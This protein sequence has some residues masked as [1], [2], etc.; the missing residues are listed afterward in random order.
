M[1]NVLIVK[2]EMKDEKYTF[3]INNYSMKLIDL[4]MYL[5]CHYM[6]TVTHPY[7]KSKNVL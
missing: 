3:I 2:G 7:T 6:E 1:D 4:T 5:Q